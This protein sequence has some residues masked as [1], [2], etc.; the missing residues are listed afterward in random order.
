[1]PKRLFDDAVARATLDVPEAPPDWLQLTGLLPPGRAGAEAWSRERELALGLVGAVRAHPLF[2]GGLPPP[3]A[4]SIEHALGRGGAAPVVRGEVRRVF[5]KD[6][7]LWLMECYPKRARESELDFKARI[8]FFLDW[9][10]LRLARPAGVP[11]HA[12][13][14][15]DG[16]HDDGWQHGF[17][18]WNRE[19]GRA[20]D[21][22]AMRAEL[23]HRVAELVAF[24]Q[25]GQAAPQWYFPG[26]SWA[27]VTAGPEK[28][29][30]CWLG[31]RGKK[32]ERDYAPGYARLLAGARDFAADADFTR[33]FANARYLRALIDL[34]RPLAGDA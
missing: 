30:E 26:T 9:A 33:L 13:I 4:V 5:E 27:L 8:P 23:E 12:C 28:A 32:G 11:V 17:A 18:D 6:G 21:P 31:M 14:V 20:A 7:A 24:A 16:K 22:L 34:S 10:L 3:H 1:V 2:A 29:R 19:F 15:I 25:R